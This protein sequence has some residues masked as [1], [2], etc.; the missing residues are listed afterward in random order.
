MLSLSCPT[1][2]GEGKEQHMLPQFSPHGK[3]RAFGLFSFSHPSLQISEDKSLLSGW[4]RYSRNSRQSTPFL[5]VTFAFLCYDFSHTPLGIFIHSYS[6]SN[7]SCCYFKTPCKERGGT[8]DLLCA[9]GG[10][11][12]GLKSGKPSCW[13]NKGMKN[14]PNGQKAAPRGPL[15]LSSMLLPEPQS[16]G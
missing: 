13:R 7:N 5:A 12:Y 1:G 8:P 16:P 15:E 14:K 10:K 9:L 2:W 4:R 6:S 3:E 11:D